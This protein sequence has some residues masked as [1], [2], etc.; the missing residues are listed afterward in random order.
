MTKISQFNANCIRA[1]LDT[2]HIFIVSFTRYFCHSPNS[3]NNTFS[4]TH[5]AQISIS[6]TIANQPPSLG[7]F[8]FLKV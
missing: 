1:Y 8:F 5:L 4:E 6:N 2:L 3:I 7:A